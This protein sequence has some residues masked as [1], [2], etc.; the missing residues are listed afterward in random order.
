LEPTGY[1]NN[2]E[3]WLSASNVLGRMNFSGALAS[4]SLPGV[5]PDSSVYANKD[6]A[7]IGRDLLGRDVSTQTLAAITQSK[8]VSPPVLASLILGSPDFQR[9]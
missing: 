2:G 7:A 6:A 4:G 5:K 1:S 8:D 3:M 9:R